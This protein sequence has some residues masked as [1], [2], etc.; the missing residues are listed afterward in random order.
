LKRFWDD[1]LWLMT[2]HVTYI[3]NHISY[4]IYLYRHSFFHIRIWTSGIRTWNSKALSCCSF[5]LLAPAR[6]MQVSRSSL[7]RKHLETHFLL[8]PSRDRDIAASRS[9]RCSMQGRTTLRPL[10]QHYAKDC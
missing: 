6:G 1:C 4:I 10:Q 8:L 7:L 5:L 2:L 3:I 9:S